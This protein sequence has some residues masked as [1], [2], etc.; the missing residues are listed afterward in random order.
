[1]S[2]SS[3]DMIREQSLYSILSEKHQRKMENLRKTNLE[4]YTKQAAT[5]FREEFRI[6][7]E[8]ANI[9]DRPSIELQSDYKYPLDCNQAKQILKEI[10]PPIL[11][12]NGHGGSYFN[13]QCH[14]DNNKKPI[15]IDRKILTTTVKW[16]MSMT[17]STQFYFSGGRR[18]E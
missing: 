9:I 2:Q 13:I 6:R 11:R 18:V 14:N 12:E 17:E 7:S 16:N 5:K 8:Y 1:M 10:I 15:N 3:K 4:E